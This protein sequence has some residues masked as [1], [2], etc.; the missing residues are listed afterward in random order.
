MHAGFHK[1]GTTTVQQTLAR[2][3]AILLPHIEI[4]LQEN[5]I[6]AGLR[7][8]VLEFSGNR[9]KE[10]KAVIYEQAC[11]FFQLLDMKDTRPILISS[12][13][14]AGH[15]PG[16]A[17]VSK[18][19]PAPIAM[20]IIHQ[21][22]KETTGSDAGFEVYYSK[23]RHGWLKSCHWQRLKANRL[24]LSLEEYERR[25]QEAADLNAIILAFKDRLSTIK[26]HHHYLEDLQHP[27]DPI[28]EIFSLSHLRNDLYLTPKLNVSPSMEIRRKLLELNRSHLKG[29]DYSKA[30]SALLRDI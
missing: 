15:F 7:R 28:L 24:K 12:E 10:T 13:S 11:A 25:F 19:A 21:A 16:N 5:A 2:N 18:Y 3:A 1:T 29:A 26:L 20:E 4:Y 14:L 23:R 27:I 9:C 22:W 30:L 8:A 17:G 6:I